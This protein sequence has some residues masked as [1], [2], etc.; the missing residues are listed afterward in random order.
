MSESFQPL[1][2]GQTLGRI[3]ERLSQGASAAVII[4]EMLPRTRD[5][6]LSWGRRLSG[7]D[8]YQRQYSAQIVSLA[9]LISRR[10]MR[11]FGLTL[12]A[13][14]RVVEESRDVKPWKTP[15][16]VTFQLE[17]SGEPVQVQYTRG[18]F[19]DGI[20]DMLYFTSPH[21]PGRPHPLSDTGYLGHLVPS[22]VV[23]ACGGHQAY[24]VLLADAILRGEQKQFKETFEGAFPK[25]GQGQ[26]RQPKRPQLTPGG[27]AARVI[28]EEEAPRQPPEQGMLF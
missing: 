14:G 25:A 23:E 21:E 12:R 24:A 2:R 15:P 9:R 16:A 6:A 22:D 17:L 28:A 4:E 18:Y 27:H 3:Q 8:E 5:E 1:S 10:T 19:P 7:W 11:E 13:D 26:R 20:T